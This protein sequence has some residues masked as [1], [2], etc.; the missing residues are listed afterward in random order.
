MRLS[1]S[2]YTYGTWRSKEVGGFKVIVWR[3][4]EVGK[5]Q[6]QTG[7]STFYGGVDPYPQVF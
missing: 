6:S 2:C 7:G 4:T 5:P 3:E 1:H